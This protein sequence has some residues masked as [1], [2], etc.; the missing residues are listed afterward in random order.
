MSHIKIQGNASGAGV[1]TIAAPAAATDKT[2]TLPD[3][4]GTLLSTGS[5][6][7]GTGPAFSAYQSSSQSLSAGASTKLLFQSE[8]YDTGNSYDT[9]TSRFSPTVAGYYL[10]SCAVR[11]PS[12]SNRFILEIQKNGTVTKSLQDVTDLYAVSGSC[13]LY[14]NGS[15]DYLE[16]YLYTGATGSLLAAAPNTFLEAALI[17]SAT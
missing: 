14:M 9:T 1:V 12:G 7:A 6:F 5:T 3:N 8:L 16:A 2:L 4:T 11:M 13:L 10:V 15:G 17:R